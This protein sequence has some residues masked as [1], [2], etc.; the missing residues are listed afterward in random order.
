MDDATS[1]IGLL[2]RR[3]RFQGVAPTAPATTARPRP[4]ASHPDPGRPRPGAARHRV[5][6]GLLARGKGALGAHVRHCRSAC[7]RNSGSPASPTWSRPTASSRRSSCHNTT[8]ASRPRPR[9]G[10][11]PSSPARRHPVHSHRYA[12]GTSDPRRP[13]PPPLRQ[14]Q[15]AEYPDGTMAV[16]HG[17]RCHTTW[18]TDRQP[19]RGRVTRFDATDRRPVDK[20]TAAPRPTTSPQ[21]QKPQQKRSIIWY[22]NRSTQN[23][24]HRPPED[25]LDP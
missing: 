10:A 20:W 24:P 25:A 14:G 12:P 22:I 16:F 23:V 2:R 11:P 19:K 21:G 8:P 13:P 1:D 5:D 4:A 15:G 18:P 3:R 9:T 6:P 7:P 17:P